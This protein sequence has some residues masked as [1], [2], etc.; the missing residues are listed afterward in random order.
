MVLSAAAYNAGDRPV[1]EW[2]DQFGDPRST[3]VDLVD[4]VEMIPYAE[5]RN[6]VQRVVENYHCYR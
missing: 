4:W 3:G 6:Y 5:T 2:I 1:N